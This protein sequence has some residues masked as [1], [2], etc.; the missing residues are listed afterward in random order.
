MVS[1]VGIGPGGKNYILP[2]AVR[3]FE[4]SDIII[5]FGRA[6]ESIDFID[7]EKKVV[8]KLDEIPDF[9]RQN[10]NKKIAVAAS[11]DPCFYGITD[12]LKKNDI[13][14][15]RVVPGLS[16]FQYFMAKINKSWQ[17]G[18]LG[19]LHGREEDLIQ[20]V[21]TNELSVWLLDSRHSL[22]YICGVLD[23]QALDVIVYVGENLS[24]DDELITIGC[25]SVLKNKGCSDLSIVAVENIRFEGK[26]DNGL[27]KG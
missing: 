16:S 11:G 5:G 12:Y 23:D 2:E 17:G 18:Y 7:R 21:R 26:R 4:D 3:C 9:I 1:V 20:K 25:P 19:S 15:F 27:Y 10:P 22:S 6:V 14:S 13:F 8:E 24:Y